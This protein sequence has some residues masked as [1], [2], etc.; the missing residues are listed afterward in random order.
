MVQPGDTGFD[1]TFSDTL[2]GDSVVTVSDAF[3]ADG[4]ANVIDA[5]RPVTIEPGPPATLAFA[6]SAFSVIAGADSPAVQVELRDSQGNP[7]P[8]TA[9]TVVKLSGCAAVAQ[10]DRDAMTARY[11]ADTKGWHDMTNAQQ[12]DLDRVGA[13]CSAKDAEVKTKL[14]PCEGGDAAAMR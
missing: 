9:P 2:A 12:S 4:E 14:A 6:T 10:E 8:A 1:F 5:S 13:E 3:P 11:D 7:T